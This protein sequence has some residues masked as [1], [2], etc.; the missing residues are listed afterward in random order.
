MSGI[1]SIANQFVEVLVVFGR[2]LHFPTMMGMFV[3]GIVMR[4]LLYR[5]VKRHYWF[6]REFE[7]RVTDFLHKENSEKSS[8]ISFYVLTKKLL[9]RSYFEVFAAREQE[10]RSKTDTVMLGDD[11]VFLTKFGCA[12]FVKELLKQLRF[13]QWGQ[14]S[15][16]LSN[17]TRTVIGKNP[18]FSRVLGFVPVGG[19]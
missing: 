7:H 2:A 5:T 8:N 15:P 16:K 1:E 18:A 4:Y 9:E 19:L 3:M 12:W 11:R 13:V 14:A 10:R 6:A 17:I